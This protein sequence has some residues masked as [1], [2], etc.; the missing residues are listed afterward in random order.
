[1]AFHGEL[2]LFHGFFHGFYQDLVHPTGPQKDMAGRRPS[3]LSPRGAAAHDQRTRR[4]LGTLR[5]VGEQV[6]DRDLRQGGFL[7]G[8]YL[9]NHG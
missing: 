9:G 4:G 5:G 8:I 6:G 3:Q 2:R 7:Y 1:M